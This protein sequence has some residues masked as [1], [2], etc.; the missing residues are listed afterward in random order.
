V[1]AKRHMMVMKTK[2]AALDGAIMRGP[3]FLNSLLFFKW[4]QVGAFYFN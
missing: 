4:S 1:E 3:V 2:G